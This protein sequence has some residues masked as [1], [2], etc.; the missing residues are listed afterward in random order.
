MGLGAG[1][2]A[3]SDVTLTEMR[4]HAEQPRATVEKKPVASFYSCFQFEQG[5]RGL[6][7]LNQRN[8]EGFI[9]YYYLLLFIIIYTP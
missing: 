2:K 9:I 6:V 1:T 8:S 5:A 4:H 3:G 7:S